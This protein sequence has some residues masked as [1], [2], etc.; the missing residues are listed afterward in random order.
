MNCSKGKTAN[1]CWEPPSDIILRPLQ[2]AIRPRKVSSVAKRQNLKIAGRPAVRPNQ[3]PKH[4]ES[5]SPSLPH[6]SSTRNGGRMQSEPF[7]AGD[8][9]LE[10]LHRSTTFSSVPD[11]EKEIVPGRGR[12]CFCASERDPYDFISGPRENT[13]WSSALKELG[14]EKFQTASRI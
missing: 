10:S 8:T 13:L 7:G 1:A 14:P 6:G 4:S 2:I 9:Q 3:P 5:K 12:T 11:R